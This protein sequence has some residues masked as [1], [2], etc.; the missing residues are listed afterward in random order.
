MNIKVVYYSLTG[1][2]KKLALR[3][4]D[5]LDVEAEALG[6]SVPAISSPV[7]LLF[8]GG[9]INAGRPNKR[10]VAFIDKLDSE[11]IKAAAVFATYAGVSRIGNDIK[12]LL[13]A[14][15][16]KVIAEP[17]ICKGHSWLFLNRHRPNA[18]DL[19]QA[20]EYAQKTAAQIM[21][22]QP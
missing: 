22:N 11:M 20:A 9:A 7:D 14:K 5:S 3:I 2:T 6:K 1:N 16:I 8:I 10:L 13:E 17:F 18:A 15:D 12:L 4:A 19:K 21:A